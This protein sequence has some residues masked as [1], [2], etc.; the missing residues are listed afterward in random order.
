MYPFTMCRFALLCGLAFSTM[1][2]KD[3][4]SPES[5]E[6]CANL[7]E[8]NEN[9]DAMELYGGSIDECITYCVETAEDVAEENPE[10]ATAYRKMAVCVSQL[11]CSEYEEWLDESGDYPCE[12]V[13]TDY[14]SC[15]VPYEED[16]YEFDWED[17]AE[18]D[19]YPCEAFAEKESCGE[20]DMFQLAYEVFNISNEF[21]L[22]EIA[23]CKCIRGSVTISTEYLET[24]EL[25]KLELVGK[26]LA[27][28]NNMAATRVSMPALREIDS[29]EFSGNETLSEIS[30]P[31][32]V[33][34]GSTLRF[35]NE[36][37]VEELSF[38]KLTRIGRLEMDHC[39]PLTNLDG[40]SSLEEISTSSVAHAIKLTGTTLENLD[41]LSGVTE[42]NSSI[43]I[44]GNPNLSDLDGLMNVSRFNTDWSAGTL[45]I[46]DN[47]AL[48]TCEALDLR[49]TLNPEE[50][51][52]CIMDNSTDDCENDYSGC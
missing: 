34:I 42:L 47:A 6:Y 18:P 29:L 26:T 14:Y 25:S 45:L 21:E 22:D 40:L 8:T 48:P 24:I 7:C 13:S 43:Y 50:I 35:Y 30:M 16:E 19:H 28:K 15:M 38:S 11:S 5:S 41:G 31:A 1:S 3:D 10:C 51:P 52:I 36:R 32:L 17:Y 12:E 49:D 46:R 4:S 33:E 39:G 2:C 27:I 9:C 37:A 20:W 23:D 44:V